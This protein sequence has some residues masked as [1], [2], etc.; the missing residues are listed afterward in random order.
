MTIQQCINTPTQ[1]L[2][3]RSD[4]YH[5]PTFW[6]I[7]P[8]IWNSIRIIIIKIKIKDQEITKTVQGVK[9]SQD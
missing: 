8:R 3:V 5:Q 2:R 9:M 1:I 6:L 7:P 4:A